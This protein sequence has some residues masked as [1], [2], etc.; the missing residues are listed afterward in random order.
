MEKSKMTRI[1][2]GYEYQLVPG[3]GDSGNHLF[4]ISKTSDGY[5]KLYTASP[6]DY[7]AYRTMINPFVTIRLRVTDERGNYFEKKFT[8]NILDVQ[9]V[10][11]KLKVDVV[12]IGAGGGGGAADDGSGGPGGS[13]SQ[14]A[15]AT[16]LKIGTKYGLHV[17]SGGL[18]G[19][20]NAFQHYTGTGGPGGETP[21]FSGGFY[22]GKGGHCGPHGSSG[23]GGGGGAATAFSYYKKGGW[24]RGWKSM[25]AAAGGGGGTGRRE[26]PAYPGKGGD[27][28]FKN[29][30]LSLYG[31]PKTVGG[32]GFNYTGDGPGGG[33]GGGGAQGGQGA[34]STEGS[35]GGKSGITRTSFKPTSVT[36]VPGQTG[37][38]VA[39][40]WHLHGL[41]QRTPLGSAPGKWW[42]KMNLVP[43]EAGSGG[44]SGYRTSDRGNSNGKAGAAIVRYKDTYPRIALGGSYSLSG[45]YHIHVFSGSSSYSLE[46]ELY[47]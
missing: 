12:L 31:D 32:I 35:Y 18:G 15:F 44:F 26:L 14:Y 9:E 8:L 10:P 11:D 38:V 3:D 47:E 5:S 45:G 20:N 23:G 22:G 30:H 16:T 39:G 42:N 46:V 29:T 6:I 33:A 21:S 41:A 40:S 34:S 4:K 1:F 13:G 24:G 17:G 2:K 43:A 7:E 37:A 25:A 36:I 19:L 27:L 28:E